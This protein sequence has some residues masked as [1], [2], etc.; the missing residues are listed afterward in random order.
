MFIFDDTKDAKLKNRLITTFGQLRKR[1]RP[2]CWNDNTLWHI[3]D[4]M[5]FG[6]SK[7]SI[8]IQLADICTYFTSRNIRHLTDPDKFFDVIKGSTKCSKVEPEWTAI[9]PAIGSIKR[10]PVPALIMQ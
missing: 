3:H 2:Q 1:V 8:G 5:Y 7:S 9:G 4:D 10:C 6:D